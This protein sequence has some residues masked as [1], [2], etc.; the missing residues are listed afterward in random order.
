LPR[1]QENIAAADIELTQDDPKRID[2]IKVAG[3]RYPEE[4]E[5]KTG[6]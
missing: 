2:R 5:K 4:S 6:L 1:L 3:E